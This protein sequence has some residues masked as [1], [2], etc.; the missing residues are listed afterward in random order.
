MKRPSQ[1]LKNF[2]MF[3]FTD[4]EILTNEKCFDNLYDLYKY[5]SFKNKLVLVRENKI[6][7]ELPL[8][9]ISVKWAV[10]L[11]ERSLHF[12]EE[13]RPFDNRPRLAIEAAKQW[14]IDPNIDVVYV[15][16]A[17][18]SAD[19]ATAYIHT[20]AAAAA[21][22]DSAYAASATA[23]DSARAAN[24]ADDAA[25]DAHIGSDFGSALPRRISRWAP[26]RWL[27]YYSYD[28]NWSR[29]KL[30]EI[31]EEYILKNTLKHLIIP[32]LSD[33]IIKYVF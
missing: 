10:A 16:A 1:F 5:R 25:A 6:M 13:K 26:P 23:V 33:I 8:K 27:S 4:N 14:I 22:A 24:A 28:Q 21:A 30:K 2:K 29:N 17:Y 18:Y 31:A 11:A 3:T 9:M 19:A 20:S 15:N 7:Y 32:E 12:F